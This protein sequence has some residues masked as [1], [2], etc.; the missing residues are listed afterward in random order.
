[1]HIAEICEL[2]S[3]HTHKEE[4]FHHGTSMYFP[5]FN[6]LKR[7]KWSQFEQHIHT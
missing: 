1:M 4:N 3:T 2:V 7:L 6:L 5:P